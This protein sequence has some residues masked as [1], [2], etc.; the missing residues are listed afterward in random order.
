MKTRKRMGM[1]CAYVSLGLCPFTI[2]AIQVCR[3][4]YLPGA[5]LVVQLGLVYL[6]FRFDK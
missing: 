1:L 6:S 3:Y 5:L 2:V 4:P